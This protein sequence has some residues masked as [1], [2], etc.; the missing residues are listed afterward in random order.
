MGARLASGKRVK[1]AGSPIGPGLL[2]EAFVQSLWLEDV[3]LL[4]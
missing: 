2:T 4:E 3:K 1:S